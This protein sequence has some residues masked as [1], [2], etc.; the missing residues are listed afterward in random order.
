MTKLPEPDRRMPAASKH[1]L[2]VMIGMGPHGA[3][4]SGGAHVVLGLL[5]ALAQHDHWGPA[6]RPDPVICIDSSAINVI[7]ANPADATPTT[8]SMGCQVFGNGMAYTGACT[9]P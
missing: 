9:P 5:P 7:Q 3:S 1:T 6:Q 4:T 8:A 2:P